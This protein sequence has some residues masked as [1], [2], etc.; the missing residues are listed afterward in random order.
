MSSGTSNN[1]VNSST[2]ILVDSGSDPTPGANV[3]TITLNIATFGESAVDR[4]VITP[5]TSIFYNQVG[6]EKT[7][8]VNLDVSGHLNVTGYKYNAIW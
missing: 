4:F 7:P 8:L 6:I 2:Y 1:L 5:T 3:G